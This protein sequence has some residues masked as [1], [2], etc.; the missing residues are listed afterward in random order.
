MPY[1]TSIE[2]IGREI[3]RKEGKAEG[4]AEERQS[5][6]SLLLHQ[7]VGPLP[8][9]VSDRITKLSPDQQQNLAIALLDF[10]A[11]ADLEAWLD[12]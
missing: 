8:K 5:L 7:K 3:G 1:I 9:K 11:I 12:P 2:R 4:K 10:E 6:V